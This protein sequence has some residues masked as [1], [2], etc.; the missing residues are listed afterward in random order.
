M[1]HARNGDGSKVLDTALTHFRAGDVVA[2][3]AHD[4]IE[5]LLPD[6]SGDQARSVVTRV[7]KATGGSNLAVGLAVA[8][9]DADTRERLIRSARLTRD[10]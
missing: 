10:R 9:H 6:T 3:Y 5:L 2:T 4:Q 1:V 7:L 8:P